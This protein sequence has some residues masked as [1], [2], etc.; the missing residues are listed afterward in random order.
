MS[1]KASLFIAVIATVLAACSGG[2]APP[3]VDPA[4]A[5]K[6]ATE[7]KAAK[8]TALYEQMRKAQSISVY[9]PAGIRDLQLELIAVT[10]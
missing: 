7:A 10:A 2:N 6:A 5:A 3:P 8:E 4:V 1:S 9:V